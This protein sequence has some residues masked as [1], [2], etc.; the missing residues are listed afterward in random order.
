M[1]YADH[2]CFM[3]ELRKRKMVNLFDQKAFDFFIHM[4]IIIYENT[5]KYAFF[6]FSFYSRL[7]RT[8]ARFVSVNLDRRMHV[9]RLKQS[10]P[11]VYKYRLWSLWPFDLTGYTSNAKLV[12]IIYSYFT[13]YANVVFLFRFIVNG[14]L[15]HEIARDYIIQ[16]VYTYY[17]LCFF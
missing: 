13:I 1:K 14:L 10:W 15:R 17:V 4:Y 5:R 3:I 7:Y 12:D 16:Q 11:N 2:M 8:R 9:E 6:F